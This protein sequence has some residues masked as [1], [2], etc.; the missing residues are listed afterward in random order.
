MS[1]KRITP[2]EVVA[3]YKKTGLRPGRYDIIP[4]KGFCCGLGAVTIAS[5]GDGGLFGYSF[6]EAEYGSEYVSG[7]LLGFD[8]VSPYRV[9]GDDPRRQQGF[10]DGWAAQKR[11]YE[12][13]V[14]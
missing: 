4:H 3:A 11:A 14:G 5:D 1:E 2:E 10:D 6:V 8:A 13:F 7:F 9:V 12:E